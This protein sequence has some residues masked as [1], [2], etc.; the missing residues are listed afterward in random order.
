MASEPK[1][2]AAIYL[3]SVKWS[4]IA[5]LRASINLSKYG[6]RCFGSL[7]NNVIVATILPAYSFD[8]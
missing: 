5:S 4:V 7:I 2:L 1:A 8:S 3:T 6:N